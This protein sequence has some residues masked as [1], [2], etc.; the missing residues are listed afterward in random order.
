MRFDV[1][2]LFPEIISQTFSFGVTGRALKRG[3]IELYTW[4]P[5]DY[6]SSPSGRVDAK[7]YSGG[8]G[9]VMQVDP[10]MQAIEA[11]KYDSSQPAHVVYM[12]AQGSP[13]NQTKIRELLALPKIILL[14]GRYEGIDQRAINHG[15]DEEISIGDFIVSG[16]ELPSLI[17]MDSITRLIP[18]VLGDEDSKRVESFED[19]LLEYPQYTRPENSDYGK[20][21][22]VLLSGDPKAIERWKLKQSL[23][24]T[25]KNRPDLISSREFSTI[26]KELL[27]EIKDEETN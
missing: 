23:S 24:K 18:G 8:P 25:L 9:M 17:V 26:E 15:V 12:S 14:S 5:R 1:I 13:L 19:G 11:A 22:K 6:T 3:L 10:L 27:N 2:T 20:V 7:P 21:P 16:G 4:N